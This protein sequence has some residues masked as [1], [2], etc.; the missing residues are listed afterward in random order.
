MSFKV[1]ILT[2]KPGSMKQAETFLRN[3]NWNLFSTCDL[4]DCLHAV[5]K[6]Q[7]DFVLIAAD[8]PNRKVKSLP[9]ILSQAVA[10]KII[11]FVEATNGNSMGALNEMKMEYNL[12]ASS[13]GK[14]KKV[15][16][17]ESEQVVQDQ[18]LVEFEK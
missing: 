3:R 18:L 7:P 13:D 9:K 10:V 15:Y 12:R 16:C 14:V 2:G 17:S 4:R 6:V 5:L 8:H 1:V 11:A